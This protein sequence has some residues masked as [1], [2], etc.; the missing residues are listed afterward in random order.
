MILAYRILAGI[1]VLVLVWGT[2]YFK[3][4]ADVNSKWDAAREHDALVAEAVTQTSKRVNA[5]I[6]RQYAEITAK[7]DDRNAK[8]VRY[9]NKYVPQAVKLD[10][11]LIAIHNAAARDYELDEAVLQAPTDTETTLRDLVGTVSRNYR[12]YATCKATNAQL[13]AWAKEQKKVWEDAHAK[14]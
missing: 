11:N 14:K 3:G 8:N 7:I 2:G 9:V 10:T 13:R 12:H 4:A 6:S 5:D 1:C